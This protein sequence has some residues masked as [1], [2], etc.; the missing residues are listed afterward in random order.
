[1]AHETFVLERENEIKLFQLEPF[2][3]GHKPYIPDRS[4]VP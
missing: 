1:M 4:A 3:F 2:G